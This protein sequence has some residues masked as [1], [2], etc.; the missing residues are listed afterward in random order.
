[1]TTYE[2]IRAIPAK[3]FDWVGFCTA[4]RTKVVTANAAQAFTLE[5]WDA[6]KGMREIRTAAM[7][8][9]AFYVDKVSK[10]S[11]TIA[12]STESRTWDSFEGGHHDV[13]NDAAA[14][15][16]ATQEVAE[17]VKCFQNQK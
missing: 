14:S 10:R 6:A 5:G 2:M 7:E 13:W 16:Q 8:M 11:N 1:M 12:P 9:A 15:E 3:G 17:L 4:L